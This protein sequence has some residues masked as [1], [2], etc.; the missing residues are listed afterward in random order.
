MTDADG[1][2]R[3]EP[4]FA[5]DEVSTLRGFLAYQRATFA[6]KCE[7]LDA[8]ALATTVAASSMT[9]GGMLKHLAFVETQW[10]THRLA[11][12][13]MPQ[14]WASVD[15]AADPDWDWTSAA[16]DTPDRLWSLWRG[17][18]GDSDAAIDA[19][20]V[21]VG[22]DG[23]TSIARGDGAR[24]SLRWVVVHLIEEYARHNGHADLIREAI[25]GR[26][27]E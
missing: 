14:P 10:V 19:A 22:M 26:V 15:W 9:L 1:S 16:R 5:A 24:F 12:R 18:V 11:G 27:G 23:L 6:W 20:L 13:A 17:S 21:A 8:R 25:D 2:D 3:V 4:E 7:G